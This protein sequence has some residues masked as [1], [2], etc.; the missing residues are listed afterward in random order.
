MFGR[1]VPHNSPYRTPHSNRVRASD[2]SVLDAMMSEVHKNIPSTVKP[3]AS[4]IKRE[5][6]L[7]AIAFSKTR[8]A[9]NP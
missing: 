5:K 8:K 2:N 3:E 7:R 6:Q 1:V 9:V 4:P